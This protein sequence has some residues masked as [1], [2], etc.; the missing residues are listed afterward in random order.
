MKIYKLVLIS[1]GIFLIGITSVNAQYFGKNKPRYTDFDFQVL[2]TPHFDLYHYLSE[3]ASKEKLAQWAEAWYD[4]HSSILKDTFDQRNPLIIYNNHADFQQTNAISGN[5][6]PSTGGVTEAFKNRVVQPIAISNQKTFQVLGHELV[7]AF[8]FDLLLRGSDSTGLKSLANLPLWIVEGMAEYLSIGRIDAHT[9]MWMRN[10]VLNDDVPTL[11]ELSTSPRYFPYRYGQAFWSFLTGLYGDEIVKPL[12]LNTAKYGIEAAVATTLGISLEDL[13]D[14]WVDAINDYYKPMLTDLKDNPEGRKFL[15]EENSGRLNLSPS[16]SPNGRYMVYLSE[17]SIFTTDLFLADVRS[18]KIISKVES[19]TKSGNIDH[20]DFMESSG[21]W[22]P[23]SKEFAFVVF[24]QGKNRLIINEAETGKRLDNFELK[25]VPAFNNP[26]WSPDGKTIIVN[27]LVEGQTDLYA[28]NVRSKEVTQLTDNEYAELQ[29]SYAYSGD[30][31]V[32]ATDELSMQTGR[33]HGAWKHNLAI[34]D[35]ATREVEHLDLF[36]GAN[37]MN[38]TF[39]ENENLYFLSDRDGFRNVYRYRAEHDSLHQLTNVLTGVSGITMYSPALTVSKKGTTMLYSHY[40]GRNYDIYKARPESLEAIPVDPHD[41]SYEAALLPPG[42]SNEADLVNPALYSLDQKIL[43]TRDQ[44]LEAKYRSKFKLDYV[45]GGAGIGVG[46]S[47]TFGTSTGLVGGVSFL[48]SDILGHNKIFS[49]LALNGEIQDFGGQFMWV[50]SKG[51]VGYGASFSHIPFRFGGATFNGIDTVRFSNGVST[52]A[53]NWEINVSR[54]FRDDGRFFVQLPFSSTTRLEGGVGFSRYSSSS[55]LFDNYYDQ[56][57][58]LIAQEREKGERP[59][60]GF[61]M[62]SLNAAYVGDNSFFG[63]TA[64]LSGYRYRV[65]VDQYFG[66]FQYTSL[67]IDARKYFWFDKFNVSI[68]G[69]HYARYGA[70]QSNR[71]LG[72]LYSIDP[73]LVRG[74]NNFSLGNTN[75]I[76]GLSIDQIQGSKIAVGN[77]EVRLPFTGPEQLALIKSKFLFSDL[78]LFFDAGMTWFEND[79]F[80]ENASGRD[81]KLVSSAG[82]SMRVNL[83]GAIILEPYYAK[84]LIKDAGWNFGINFVPG[85]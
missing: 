70:D 56:F 78:N 32:F 40:Y 30:K 25:G 10:A 63:L 73:T 80:G 38:P 2:Q 71:G 13:S 28:V 9:A 60:A 65:G 20:L 53:E 4:L 22:S 46:T 68:R 54:I 82:V 12:F 31:I 34:M 6:G 14:L 3:P 26:T 67:L 39:D 62:Y 15:S 72:Y 48:F 37:N 77:L 11:K 27:G 35:L 55:T 44:V 33:V 75:E 19:K 85:W 1:C 5:V 24:A 69:L 79:Q 76:Y 18:G 52:L 83:F 17:R 64:P 7:H 36:P 23:N 58:R 29:P 59:F 21:A 51:K 57:G 74:Y 50:N 84:P 61:N 16:I 45:S 81:P 66:E 41:V 42:M 8:Q 49:T 43:L 47:T